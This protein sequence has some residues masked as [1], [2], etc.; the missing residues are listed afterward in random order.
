YGISGA[1]AHEFFRVHSLADVEHARAERT[2]L[3]RQL[4]GA[5]KEGPTALRSAGEAIDAWWQFLD[6]FT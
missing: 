2:L 5:P 4:R 1:A 3:A 6:R